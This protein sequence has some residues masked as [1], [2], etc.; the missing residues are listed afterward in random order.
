METC[1]YRNR[2]TIDKSRMKREFHV[3]FCERLGLKC[4]CLLDFYIAANYIYIMG[5]TRIRGSII[6]SMAY[7][8]PS[9]P[10]PESFTPP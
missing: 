2:F 7:L 1:I 10:M 4:P 9:R 3:R 8:T 6:S 5:F